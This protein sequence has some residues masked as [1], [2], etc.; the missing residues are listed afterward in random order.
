MQCCRHKILTNTNIM[1]LE[2]KHIAPYLPYGLKKLKTSK[3]N[4]TCDPDIT[5][6]EDV[7][8]SSINDLFKKRY[9]VKSCK[10]LLLPLSALT[11]PMEDGSVPIDIFAQIYFGGS[12]SKNLEGLKEEF[13]NNI[14][15]SP[16]GVVSFEIVEK[17]FAWH[18]DVYGLIESG[19]AIDKRTIKTRSIK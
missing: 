12:F 13:I 14:L 2:L 7:T 19:L 11:E 4:F 6:I 5:K 3:G 18:F 17:L 8:I 15:Y 10:P 9:H 16:I 1:K